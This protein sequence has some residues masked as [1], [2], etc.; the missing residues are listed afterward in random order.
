MH[1]RTSNHE[2][3]KSLLGGRESAV[4]LEETPELEIPLLFYHELINT[5]SIKESGVLNVMETETIN[6]CRLSVPL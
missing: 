5:R 1:V 2:V 4:P 3:E 6:Y